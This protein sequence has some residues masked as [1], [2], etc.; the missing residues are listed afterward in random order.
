MKSATQHQPVTPVA[1]LPAWGRTLAGIATEPLEYCAEFPRIAKR[2]EA[3]WHQELIDRPLLI[4]AANSNPDRPIT[5]R[6]DL[7]DDPDAWFDAKF[8]DMMQMHRVADAL[9]HIRTDFGPVFL[10]PLFGGRL[11]IG[12]GTGWTHA[13]IDDTWSN[14]P[15]WRIE[16]QDRWWTLFRQLTQRVAHDAAGRYL[17][18]TPDFGGS[19][20]V[21][22]N[23]RTAEA[24]CMDLVMQPAVVQ[25]S[26]DAIYAGWWQAFTEVYRIAMPEGAGIIH[27]L[28]VWAHAPYFI[29][30]C[31]FCCMIS[32]ESFHEIC[33]PDIERGA[34]TLG[35]SVFHL[36]G[37]GAARHIDA[38]LEVPSIQAIQFTPGDGAPSALPW[39]DM[40]KKIQARGRSL[41]IICP[42]SEVLAVCDELAPEGLAFIVDGPIPVKDLDALYETLCGKYGVKP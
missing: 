42:A 12:A 6:L 41:L 11:E 14:A 33:L 19:A 28:G 4:G 22:L 17:L 20:D 16:A 36:D 27:W 24:L 40:F 30:A 29:P 13:F 26:I 8:Q 2:W 32:P 9:P 31:D 35:R 25:R 7:L 1:E 38:L 39:L 18:C 15:D 5:R 3:W 37:P 10:G 34:A 21:L 23:L